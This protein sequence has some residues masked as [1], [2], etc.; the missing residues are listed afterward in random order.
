MHLTPHRP[1]RLAFEPEPIQQP[2]LL[3]LVPI[4]E[5]GA[6]MQDLVIVDERGLARPQ[7][8]LEADLMTLRHLL[9]AGERRL[10]EAGQRLAERLRAPIDNAAHIAAA[11]HPI[12]RRKYRDTVGRDRLVLGRLLAAPIAAEAAL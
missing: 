5:A 9:E 11:Q 6:R 10:F 1:R 2:L 4:D 3:R 12:M 8:H 7:H